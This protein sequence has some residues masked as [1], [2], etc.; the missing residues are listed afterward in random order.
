MLVCLSPSILGL[1]TTRWKY[2]TNFVLVDCV[3]SGG[4]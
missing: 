3:A 1:G 2:D 4:G